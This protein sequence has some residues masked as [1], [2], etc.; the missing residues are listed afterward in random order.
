[1]IADFK[2]TV[3]STLAF[4]NT[5]E[6]IPPNFARSNAKNEYISARGMEENAQKCVCIMRQRQVVTSIITPKFSLITA[7]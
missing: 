7:T 5:L 1:M 4:G 6:S 2:V 3:F